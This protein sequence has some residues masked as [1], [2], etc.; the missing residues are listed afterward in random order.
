[1]PPINSNFPSERATQRSR[2]SDKIVGVWI[3]RPLAIWISQSSL[4]TALRNE[5]TLAMMTTEM[6]G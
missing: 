6:D 3:A 5:A 2:N 1:M 4:S